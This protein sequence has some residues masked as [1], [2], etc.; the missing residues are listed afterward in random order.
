MRILAIALCALLAPAA[1][2]AAEP[3]PGGIEWSG[4]YV[5][6]HFGG[7]FG[8]S[9]WFDLGAGNIGSHDPDGIIGGGQIGY[10]FQHGP[11][12]FGPEASFSGSTLGGKHLD[13][14]FQFGPAPEF[15]RGEI[16][17]I[18]TLT[19]RLGYASGPL[20]LYG[21]GGAAFA[22][23]RNT[24]VGFFAPGLEFAVS[25]KTKWGWLAGAG[26]EYEFA[27]RWTGFL[28]YN[29]LGFGSDLA[30]LNC[31]AVRNCGPPGAT[32]VG[33]SIRENIHTV[34]TGINFRF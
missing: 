21:K 31:T 10:N 23:T 15:D 16:D 12:V 33:I 1:A 4:F 29:Y 24:L 14:V 30:T 27:P 7:A 34:K 11:W 2:S 32:S 20:L 13:A 22:H 25:D 6:G 28:E 17:F 18:G 19:G 8:S 26:A 9:D 5:G 3:P